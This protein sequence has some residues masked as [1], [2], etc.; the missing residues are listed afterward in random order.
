MMQEII[1]FHSRILPVMDDGSRSPE[2]SIAM[3]R[4]KAVCTAVRKMM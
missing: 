2:E 3:L 4:M 1:D